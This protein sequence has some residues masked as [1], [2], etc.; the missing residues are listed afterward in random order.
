MKKYDLIWDLCTSCL[1]IY[2]RR[3]KED[4]FLVVEVIDTEFNKPS[5]VHLDKYFTKTYVPTTNRYWLIE[6]AKWR[7]KSLEPLNINF[8]GKSKEEKLQIIKEQFKIRGYD[9]D[10]TKI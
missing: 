1:L 6:D 7:T 3:R 5:G 2:V 9:F 4:K 10:E 8:K